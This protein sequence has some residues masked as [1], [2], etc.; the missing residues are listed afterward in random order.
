MESPKKSVMACVL[1]IVLMYSITSINA[2]RDQSAF[3]DSI[4]KSFDLGALRPKSD[5]GPVNVTVGMYINSFHS[6]KEVNM[7]YSVSVYLSMRWQDI[8]LQ[9]NDT[10]PIVFN[11]PEFMDVVWRPDIYFDNEKRGQ[12]HK[13][14]T[15]NRALELWPDGQIAYSLRLSL[16][17][18]CQMKLQNFPMDE[19]TCSMMLLSYA[20]D[21]N[22][23]VLH[24]N[25]GIDAVAMYPDIEMPQF[26][27]INFKYVEE[28]MTYKHMKNKSCLE[29]FFYLKREMGYYILTNFIPSSLLV[30]LSWVSF[31]LHLDATA[32]RVALGITTVLTTATQLTIAR[33]SLPEVSYP[34]AI[35]VWMTSCMFFVFAALIEFAAVNY[36]YMYPKINKPKKM[37]RFEKLHNNTE[38]CQTA[39]ELTAFGLRTD[40]VNDKNYSNTN[41]ARD[42]EACQPFVKSM[43]SSCYAYS[44]IAKSIDRG[45]RVVFPSLFIFF[46]ICYWSTYSYAS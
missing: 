38:E 39:V 32:A 2:V 33:G 35:D 28:I 18:S 3:V 11:S 29:V 5:G 45:A 23:V 26:T 12:Y 36:I 16:T 20:Y 44:E 17:L 8:R 4:M 37:D 31:W 43:Q 22:N 9:H 41:N 24:W 10:E 7:E 30:I 19:H 1:L 40:V 6:V 13:V 27:L 25:E 21:A 14:T 34:T 46:N 42:V 15:E